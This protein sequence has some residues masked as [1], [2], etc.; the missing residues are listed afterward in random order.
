LENEALNYVVR[1]ASPIQNDKEK[2]IVTGL[3]VS[4]K[5]LRRVEKILD[6]K[7]FKL[8]VCKVVAEWC[9]AYYLQYGTAPGRD[10]ETIY[11]AESGLLPEAVAIDVADFLENISS[12]YITNPPNED[13]LY[14]MAEDFLKKQKLSKISQAVLN[15]LN[16]DGNLE[17]AEH[18]ITS[19]S[20]DMPDIGGW[21]NPFDREF[22]IQSME[23]RED[24]LVTLPSGLGELFGPLY[25]KWLVGLMGPMKRGKTRWMMELTF[26]FLMA[27]RRCLW[28]TCEMTEMDLMRLLMQRIT[29]RGLDVNK[30]YHTVNVFDCRHNY[31]NLCNK[32]ERE[33]RVENGMP[34]YRV[35]SVCKDLDDDS[36]YDQ[37][38]TQVVIHRPSLTTGSALH[39]MENF[40]QMHGN[41]YLRM[42]SYPPFSA[43]LKTIARDIDILAHEGFVPDVIFI[44]YADILHPENTRID[45][46][47]QQDETWKALKRLAHERNCL[48]VSATQGSRATLAKDLIEQTDVS[49]DIRK[50]AHVDVFAALSQSRLEKPQGL[51]RLNLLAHRWKHFD[52]Y[53]TLQ[54]SYAYDL[55]Q[56]FLENR[57][58]TYIPVNE[59]G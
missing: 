14:D 53:E 50:L 13:M 41:N 39:E 4:G 3:V 25:R 37:H 23:D 15:V 54:V 28:I 58:V 24:P 40:M 48:V 38:M 46:R 9:K 11:T 34:G 21:V 35:C 51:M 36:D 27:R 2:R 32:A 52:P 5:L 12:E 44:D 49:E 56:A 10:I 42:K 17:D 55:G 7:L 43:N 45:F 33:C 30:E 18:L 19:Y 57:M 59:G 29:A 31:M 6:P 26:W 16:S 20:H 47:H 22:I 8:D 1:R